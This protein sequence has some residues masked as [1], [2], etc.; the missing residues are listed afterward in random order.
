MLTIIVVPI[1]ILSPIM[2]ILGI[3]YLIKRPKLKQIK[4]SDYPNI[5]ESE[6][7]A[8]KTFEMKSI[9]SLIKAAFGIPIIVFIFW[10]ID[11]SG[12]AGGQVFIP[13]FYLGILAY[14]VAISIISKNSKSANKI[15]KKYNLKDWD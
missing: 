6:F 4:A 12:N 14:I 10:V 9:N 3:I 5:P 7:L 15:K 1:L 11:T 8:W 13:I 2:M